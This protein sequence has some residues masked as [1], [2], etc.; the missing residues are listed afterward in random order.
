MIQ[1]DL[2]YKFFSE[3][4][5]RVLI[6]LD[7]CRFDFFS[8]N[9][10]I[11]N[12]LQRTISCVLS[13]GSCTPEWLRNTFTE[14]IDAVYV[15]ANPFV[16]KVFGNA[17]IF[18]N[19]IDVSSRYMDRSLGTVKPRHVNL[20]A[21]K[22]LLKKENLIVHYLQPHMPPLTRTWLH[23][24]VKGSPRIAA[25]I[26]ALARRSRRAR[27]EFV[28]QYTENI[29]HVLFFAK[30]LTRAAFKLG[31]TGVAIT[32]DHGE[33]LGRYDPLLACKI[34]A[35]RGVS[36]L[37]MHW[38]LYALGI[39]RLVGHPCRLSVHELREVPWVEIYGFKA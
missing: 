13:A 25:G 1:R 19:I 27:E 7:A 14:P 20:V 18:K 17:K 9:A 2:I 32:S 30:E 10:G 26:Y 5:R 33:F 11:L 31:Y 35:R 12:D 21:L 3:G 28:K 16:L 22:F 38:F 34:L 15:T 39:Y 37:L 36:T 29:K 8:E 6:V 23:E 4:G 24:A